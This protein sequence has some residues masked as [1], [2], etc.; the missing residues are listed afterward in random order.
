MTF[1][2]SKSLL[3]EMDK[4]H[5]EHHFS[6]RTEFIRAAIR[7]KIERCKTVNFISKQNPNIQ[8]KENKMDYTG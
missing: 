2:I 4:T 5:Q 3:E 6:N 7:E 1:K 8:K